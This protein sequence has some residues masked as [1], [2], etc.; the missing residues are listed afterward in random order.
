MHSVTDLPYEVRE[1]SHQWIPVADGVRLA[2]RIWRP[3]GS[4]DTPVPALLE[5]IPYRHNGVTAHRDSIHHPYLAGHGYA[6]VRVDLRGSGQSEGILTDEYLSRELA[7]AE[8]VLAWIAAQPWC[9]SRMGMMGIS[10]GGFNAL[11]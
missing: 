6:C 4:D 8:A 1:D 3:V 10:W 2:A 7:D 5:M 9:T 11:Q